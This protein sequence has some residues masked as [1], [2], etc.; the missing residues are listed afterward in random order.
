M[1]PKLFPLLFQGS[2]VMVKA[3]SVE[4]TIDRVPD[5]HSCSANER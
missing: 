3:R 4:K 5:V 1:T 2:N